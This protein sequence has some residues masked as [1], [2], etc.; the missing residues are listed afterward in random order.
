MRVA[1]IGLAVIL[2]TTS[3]ALAQ[4]DCKAEPEPAVMSLSDF[5]KLEIEAAKTTLSNVTKDV[6]QYQ[7]GV[8]AER[9][10]LETQMKAIE[11]KGKEASDAEK[12]LL[13]SLTETYNA[14][15]DAEAALGKN[16]NA[17]YD[18]LCA[19]GEKGYCP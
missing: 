5:E 13:N 3:S 4:T 8:A 7:T 16:V 11:D 12:K 10:C 2:A 6:K 9:T 14:T 1:F 19:R 17:M 15:V 18:S